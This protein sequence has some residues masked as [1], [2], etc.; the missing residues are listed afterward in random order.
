MKHKYENINKALERA[1]K[2]MLERGYCVHAVEGT[3]KNNPLISNWLNV[4]THGLEDYNLTNISIVAPEDDARLTEVIYTVADMM[5]NGEEFILNATHFIDNPDGSCKF[6]FKMLP[7][8]CFGE[9][10]IRLILPDPETND[11]FN[12][13][14]GEEGIYCLQKTVLFEHCEDSCL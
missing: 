2:E 9:D 14:D 5:K 6:K 1:R 11:F 7:T 13:E 10:T 8:K 3:Y 12:D 4:H